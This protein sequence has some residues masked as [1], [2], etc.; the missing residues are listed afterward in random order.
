VH[1]TRNQLTHTVGQG[2]EQVEAEVGVRA[3]Q[4]A[5]RKKDLGLRVLVHIDPNR[6]REVEIRKGGDG[7]SRVRQL[8]DRARPTAL[9]P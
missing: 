3:S 9:R 5:N 1:L 2:P 4:R 8:D 7:G 6:I